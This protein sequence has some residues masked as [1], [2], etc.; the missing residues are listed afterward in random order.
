MKM[1][2]TAG[3]MP[4]A[5]KAEEHDH[6]RRVL[7]RDVK[8]SHRVGRPR[9]TRR[10]G[11]L[12]RPAIQALQVQQY[13]NGQ[14]LARRVLTADPKHHRWQDGGVVVEG[15]NRRECAHDNLSRALRVAQGI[16]RHRIRAPP[17]EV[18]LLQARR[19][20]PGHWRRVLDLSL[21][22]AH[23]GPFVAHSHRQKRVLR[24]GDLCRGRAV[25]INRQVPESPIRAKLDISRAYAPKGNSRGRF[26]R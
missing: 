25:V 18:L 7:L 17:G 6:R 21:Q 4:L 9:P 10:L 3:S 26:P 20:A 11:H 2:E 16:I 8:A 24:H 14:R 13:R 19:R 12:R 5:R 23:I 1:L 15:N 22:D